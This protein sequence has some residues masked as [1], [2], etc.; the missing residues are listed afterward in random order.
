MF[1]WR[2]SAAAGYETAMA[3]SKP[4][5]EDELVLTVQAPVAAE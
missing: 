1:S 3:D 2:G 4:L 5:A